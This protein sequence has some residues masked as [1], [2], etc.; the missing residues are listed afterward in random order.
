MSKCYSFVFID[1]NV[2]F[3]YLL[4]L[5]CLIEP[6]FKGQRYSKVCIQDMVWDR[7]LWLGN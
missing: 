4:C 7:K 6:N 5:S 3:A 2:L 1:K